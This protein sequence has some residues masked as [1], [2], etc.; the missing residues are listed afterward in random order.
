[1]STMR[2]SI[3]IFYIIV[4]AVVCWAKP[5]LSKTP[6][7]VFDK[8]YEE[9][10]MFINGQLKVDP[11]YLIGVIN[12]TAFHGR[13][14]AEEL[15]LGYRMRVPSFTQRMAL[16]SLFRKGLDS[17]NV[18]IQIV[19]LK[20]F[21]YLGGLNS[22][23]IAKVKELTKSTN[24]D[25]RAQAYAIFLEYTRNEDQRLPVILKG[26][27]DPSNKV[28]TNTIA[29]ISREEFDN[30]DILNEA[31]ARA[32][33]F[34]WAKV[35]KARKL[36]FSRP[37][38]IVTALGDSITYGYLA[39]SQ[40]NGW[41]PPIRIGVHS[42]GIGYFGIPNFE[43]Y[44]PSNFNLS[45][46]NSKTDYSYMD[47]LNMYLKKHHLG[48]A[49]VINKSELGAVS[50]DG[51]LAAKTEIVNTWKYSARDKRQFIVFY[52]ANDICDGVSTRQFQTNINHILQ[53]LD[54]VESTDPVEVLLVGP[55]P[56]DQ[57]L[58]PI[59][60]QAKGL[61]GWSCKKIHTVSTKAC[62]LLYS[63]PELVIAREQ[64]YN[65]ALENLAKKYARS[66]HLEVTATD[67]LS[68]FDVKPE[69]LAWDCFHPSEIGQ[70]IIAKMLWRA[71]PW[72]K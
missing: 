37:N 60:W 10:K 39:Q 1:M 59:I 65:I 8:N 17:S 16:L 35:R 21:Y 14:T 23:S 72:F 34:K 24:A 33:L 51:I 9:I 31:S 29:L 42:S 43:E 45:W 50:K 64:R 68:Q 49:K 2:S 70:A 15:S 7:A 5:S 40:L 18:T 25:V 32:A 53:T 58:K 6:D 54:A 4:L 61:G 19:S 57:I 47:L 67:V 55:P 69:D 46:L 30:M 38:V 52:G 27:S 12:G 13:P 41:K 56:I 36:H 22:Q 3:A 62:P 44:L 11:G 26:L 20:E 66:K 71:Q 63:N 28:F 48:W